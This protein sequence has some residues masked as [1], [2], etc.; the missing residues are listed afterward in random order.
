MNPAQIDATHQLIHD[1]ATQGVQAIERAGDRRAAGAYYAEYCGRLEGISALATALSH[2]TGDEQPQGWGAALQDAQAQLTA[3]YLGD[4][5]SPETKAA[6]QRALHRG[7]RQPDHGQTAAAL[8]GVE[9]GDRP[10][11]MGE[12]EDGSWRDRTPRIEGFDEAAWQER[13]DLLFHNT[14][15]A[16]DWNQDLVAWRYSVAIDAAMAE[17]PEAAL[18]RAAELAKPWGYRTPQERD[19]EVAAAAGDR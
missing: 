15:R 16:D 3:A 9:R 11:T 14:K 2:P 17:L 13:C 19:A 12:L 1:M 18:G 4:V 5:A 8:A 6:A 7:V 10:A